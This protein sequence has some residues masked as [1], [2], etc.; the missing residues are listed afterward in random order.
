VN[1]GLSSA[2]HP[3]IRP[4]RVAV[5][6]RWSTEEQTDGTTLAEQRVGCEFYIKSQGW[7]VNPE[8]V[9]IDDGYS[10]GSLERP[11]M[12]QLRQLVDRGEVDCVVVL[13]IDR[14]SRN[15]VD[16]TQ[17][18]LVEWQNRCHLRCV[19]QPI[20]TTS[21]TGRMIFS[22]LATFADF[23]RA[24]ISE[25]TFAGRVRRLKE[26]KAYGGPSVPFGL[27]ATGEPGVRELDPDKAPIVAEMFRKVREEGASIM[28]LAR[29]LEEQSIAPPGRA[30]A[31]RYNSLRHML[32]NPIYAG[33]IVYGWEGEPKRP[34]DHRHHPK[35]KGRPLVDV[36]AASVPAIVPKEEFDQVQAII[37]ER[38]AFHHKHRRAADG[39]HLLSGIAQCRCG[40]GIQVHFSR[41]V[42]YYICSNRINYGPGGCTTPSGIL[43]A[44]QVE[45][46]VV[47]DLMDLYGDLTQRQEAAK[48]G[49]AQSSKEAQVLNK[50][51]GKLRSEVSRLDSRMAELRAAASLGDIRLD[52]WRELRDTLEGKRAAVTAD[53][54]IVEARL[55]HISAGAKDERLILQRL[56]Q[57][58]RWDM[59][60]C[61]EQKQFLRDFAE[62]IELYKPR[63][64]RQ[65]Y[66]VRIT[67]RLVPKEKAATE[68][69]R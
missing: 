2:I 62:K 21:E 65:K 48:K 13:K 51:L 32:S 46:A 26:G 39:V 19:R 10:G 18:V 53:M 15:I 20:D 35:R 34:S 27:R 38:C 45:Q 1:V 52:E 43:R 54:E 14:L 40:G 47:K 4:D 56:A 66:E 63:G 55:D 57:L 50:E 58:D 68:L 17:L 24:Q 37:S 41:G 36:Q 7:F 59:L 28:D 5:Y 6:I 69:G 61:A 31:W 16:A 67:W 30:K 49:N 23:E 9:F 8:L 44:E 60:T 12:R 3:E 64:H 29:W 11:G 22:I 42:K 25:R 33:R